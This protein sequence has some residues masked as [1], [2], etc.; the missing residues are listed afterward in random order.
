MIVFLCCTGF[1]VVDEYYVSRNSQECGSCRQFLTVCFQ[2][3]RGTFEIKH[4]FS[5]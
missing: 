1:E 3:L 2:Y 5:A 4:V